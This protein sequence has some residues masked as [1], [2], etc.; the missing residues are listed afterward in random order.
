MSKH[1]LTKKVVKMLHILVQLQ[2]VESNTLQFLFYYFSFTEYGA[3]E[4]S[5]FKV[6][7]SALKNTLISILMACLQR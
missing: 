5:L 2:N 6:H 3:P 1:S 7:S 4:D